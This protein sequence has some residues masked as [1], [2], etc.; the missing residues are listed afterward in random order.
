MAKEK[1]EKTQELS[2]ENLDQASGGGVIESLEVKYTMFLP[3][4]TPVRSDSQSEEINVGLVEKL[5]K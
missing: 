2:D 5:R 4:G 3:D 1:D